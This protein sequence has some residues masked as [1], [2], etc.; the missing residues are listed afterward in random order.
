MNP[1]APSRILL[2]RVGREVTDSVIFINIISVAVR[3]MRTPVGM[4]RSLVL[5][6]QPIPVDPCR[7]PVFFQDSKQFRHLD[8]GTGLL[9]ITLLI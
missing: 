7:K 4:M 1:T 5:F 9:T 3:F 8:T 2:E 6:C